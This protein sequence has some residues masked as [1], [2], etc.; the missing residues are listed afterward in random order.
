MKTV[1][2]LISQKKMKKDA[3]IIDISCDRN[4]GIETSRPTTLV[5]PIYVIDGVTHYAVDHTPSTFYK[6]ISASLSEIVSKSI[7]MLI[8]DEPNNTL[9]DALI[10]KDGIVIY[11]RINQFQNR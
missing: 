4:G 1:D 8:M 3:L 5:N 6:T 7:N 11:E 9:F 2:V 10:V